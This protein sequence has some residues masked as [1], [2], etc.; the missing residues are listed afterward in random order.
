MGRQTETADHRL[1]LRI[2][3]TTLFP[4]LAQQEVV[5]EEILHLR[6]EVAIEVPQEQAGPSTPRLPRYSCLLLME[7]LCWPDKRIIWRLTT[8]PSGTRLRV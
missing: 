8:T 7:P 4:S 3:V 1:S 5:E 6:E 2:E